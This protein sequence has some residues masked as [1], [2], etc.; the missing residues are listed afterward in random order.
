MTDEEPDPL[1][2]RYQ[3][4]SRLIARA[5]RDPAFRAALRADPKAAFEQELGMRLPA[6]LE[7]RVLEDT[8]VLYHFVIPR[9]PAG[10]GELADFELDG[11]VGG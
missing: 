1:A 3:R 4:E 11:V 9:N 10:E 6:E 2:V 8:P 7:I 5:W